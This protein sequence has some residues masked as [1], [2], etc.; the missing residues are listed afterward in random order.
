MKEKKKNPNWFKIIMIFLVIIFLTL[1]ISQITGYYEFDE[2]KRTR[3][4]EEQIKTFEKDIKDG[5]KVDLTSYLESSKKNYNNKVSKSGLKLSNML[6]KMVSSIMN[7]IVK[8]FEGLF[9]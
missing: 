6:D 8:I 7:V 9:G 3:L 5:K 1:Y 4:T 2:Y